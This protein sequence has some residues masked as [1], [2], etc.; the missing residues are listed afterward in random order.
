M[1]LQQFLGDAPMDWLLGLLA[2]PACT[3][4]LLGGYIVFALSRRSKKSKMK[5]GVT[6]KEDAPAA[7]VSEPAAA[8]Q[9]VAMPAP[10]GN[11][12]AGLDRLRSL[13]AALDD[14][15]SPAKKVTAD[16]A[17]P[18]PE[19]AR[20]AEPVAA[21]PVELLRLLRQ[22]GSGQLVV[23]VAGQRYSKLADI[24]DRK[25]GQFVLHV[26]AH[27]LAFTNGVIVTPAGIK[28]VVNP[29]DQLGEAPAPPGRS[30]P[31]K[32]RP[33]QPEP[34]VPPPSPEAEAAFRASLAASSLGQPEPVSSRPKG[35]FGFGR[36]ASASTPMPAISLA[37]EINEIVQNR[38][39]YSPPTAPVRIDITSK[40]DGGI[41]II[42]NGH[43]Y[44]SPEE[45]PDPEVKDLIKQ[46]IKEWERS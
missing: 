3:V 42:V 11:D 31:A 41:N 43:T 6:V 34:L 5:L 8:K 26:A 27:L 24:T 30:Q 21:E 1:D 14:E 13:S 16:A 23:E 19:E 9:P 7:P 38:L 18:A 20:P 4:L 36:P 10:G 2:V 29:K 45:I 15:P 25:I 40:P 37:D 17:A 33:P 44:S 39:R 32:A 46:S 22:P 35:M 28:S 12:L